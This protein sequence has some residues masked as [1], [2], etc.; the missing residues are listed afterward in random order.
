MDSI[1]KLHSIE[2]EETACITSIEHDANYIIIKYNNTTDTLLS[3]II[4]YSVVTGY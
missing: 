1:L 2:G 4:N 3:I